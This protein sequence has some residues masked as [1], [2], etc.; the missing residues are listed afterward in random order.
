MGT[1]I[2]KCYLEDSQVFCS[3]I[4]MTHPDDVVEP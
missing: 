3:C 2:G 4:A 1:G